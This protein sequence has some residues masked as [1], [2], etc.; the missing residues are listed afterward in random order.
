MDVPPA[1]TRGKE[2]PGTPVLQV[3]RHP[4]KGTKPIPSQALVSI[5]TS[6]AFSH[7][8]ALPDLC[9]EHSSG[10]QL[11]PGDCLHVTGG[12][13]ALGSSSPGTQPSLS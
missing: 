5:L 2:A 13:E 8:R 1:A 10:G 4:E 11:G 6:S 9:S 12:A 3:P 7:P